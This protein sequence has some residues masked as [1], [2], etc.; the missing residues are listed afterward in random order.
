[1]K[2][3]L[4]FILY[5]V[6]FVLIIVGAKYGYEYLSEN[7]EVDN[8]NDFNINVNTGID[9]NNSNNNKNNS[10]E[11]YSGESEQNESKEDATYKAS[12]FKVMNAN[13][14]MVNLSDYFGKPIVVN[15][16]ATWCG[17]CRAEIPDFIEAY[18]NM[19]KM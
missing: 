14:E 19:V 2:N 13:G 18:K 7:Y 5:V 15:F 4:K 16:W 12:N 10:E 3:Y 1:M 11:I 6:S 8:S 17:P 9:N